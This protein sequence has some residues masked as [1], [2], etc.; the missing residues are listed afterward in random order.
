MLAGARAALPGGTPADL[1]TWLRT[2]GR[3]ADPARADAL[4]VRVRRG[5]V[6]S[7]G[8]ARLAWEQRLGGP[9]LSALDVLAAAASEG[10]EALLAAL[11]AEAE[12]IWTAP[13]RRRADV[14]GAE[15]LAD[16]RVAAALRGAASELRGLAREDPEL[17]GAPHELLEALAAVEVREPSAIAGASR[18][19]ARRRPPACCSPSRSR[20]APAASAPCSSAAS[21]TASSRAG[22]SRTRSS[23]T[24]TGAG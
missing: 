17:L 14:L 19:P 18:R 15:D 10:P 3:V 13:H 9:S 6:R 4:E 12:G 20:S 23:P 2:P 21:R 7:V 11:E 16:A 5:E 24:T 22:R 8:A 1:L